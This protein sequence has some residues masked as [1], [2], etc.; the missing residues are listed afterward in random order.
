MIPPIP[1]S[2]THLI[3]QVLES[4]TTRNTCVLIPRIRSCD[5][6][7]GRISP[8]PYR[9]SIRKT[10]LCWVQWQRRRSKSSR[11]SALQVLPAR[12][13]QPSTRRAT[14]AVVVVRS[15]MKCICWNHLPRRCLARS[16]LK[17]RNT[18]SSISSKTNTSSNSNNTSTTSN[19]SS[20]KTISC[21]ITTC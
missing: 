14:V 16:K 1:V 12:I 21:S 8:A 15:L 13:M 3:K 20:N 10:P 4:T 9:T 11:L 5:R 2:S 7:C 17:P 19:I 18:N 6:R